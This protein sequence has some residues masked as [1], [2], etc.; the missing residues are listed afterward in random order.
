M[1]TLTT[2]PTYDSELPTLR[3]RESA[4][5]TG[6]RMACNR[7]E[8][9]KRPAALPPEIRSF[10]RFRAI[11]PIDSQSGGTWIAAS[12]AGFVVSLLNVYPTVRSTRGEEQVAVG[13]VD[14]RT[15]WGPNAAVAGKQSRGLIIPRLMG[16]CG[17]EEAVEAAKRLDAVSYPPFRLVLADRFRIV[18]LRSNGA[19]ISP[20]SQQD[21]DHP[22]LFVSS[23]L[24]DDRVEGPRRELYD[25]SFADRANLVESQDRFH[26][27]TW[28]D[29]PELSVCMSR[30]DARTVSLTVVELTPDRVT[31]VY[32]PDAPDRPV[33]PMSLSL[34]LHATVAT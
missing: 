25:S 29:R 24:G 30:Q 14:D 33:E 34:E 17:L 15:P 6:L 18:E 32:Y 3:D 5:P 11:M 9:C 23:G 27:H 31:M 20:S 19:E 26:R 1:C 10:G 12:D 7:D 8:S 4:R 22:S 21:S 28:P 13:S 2:V 16:C